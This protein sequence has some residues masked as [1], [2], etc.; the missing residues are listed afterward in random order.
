MNTI[1]IV[2]TNRPERIDAFLRAWR[3]A[4]LGDLTELEFPSV[5]IIEDSYQRRI[6]EDTIKVWSPT[7]HFTHQAIDQDL[8]AYVGCIDKQSPA[9]RSYLV[10][11]AAHAKPD[12]IISLDDDCMP[13][14]GINFIAGHERA[15]APNTSHQW[16]NPVVLQDQ[17]L[18]NR[19]LPYMLPL[20]GA[21]LNHG[22]VQG[23]PDLDAICQLALKETP[24]DVQ[25]YVLTHDIPKGFFFPMSIQNVGFR[26][27]IAP[28]MYLP[29]LPDGFKRWSDIWCGLVMKKVCDAH[30]LSVVTGGPCVRHERASNVWANLRQEWAGYEI[31]ER[32][33]RAIDVMPLNGV[34]LLDDYLAVADG[35][36]AGFPELHIM[37]DGMKEWA[38]LW[39]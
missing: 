8:G 22:L 11:K 21:V 3:M 29:K 33:W 14:Q 20:K 17:R 28:L 38:E 12:L 7:V 37:T 36:E 1:I 27:E 16:L 34:N 35:I 31:H 5:Y 2:P 9:V 24:I 10:W 23:M 19:G 32:L 4:W 15:L 18:W 26:P 39:T 25:N 6:S 13:M 30:S